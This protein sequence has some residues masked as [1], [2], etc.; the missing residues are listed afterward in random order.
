[1]TPLLELLTPVIRISPL[2]K[3]RAGRHITGVLGLYPDRM[4]M[5]RVVQNETLPLAVYQPDG[6]VALVSFDRIKDA[7]AIPFTDIVSVHITAESR[8]LARPPGFRVEIVPL[9]GDPVVHFLSYDGARWVFVVLRLRLGPRVVDDSTS[10]ALTETR[11]PPAPASLKPLSQKPSQ[12]SPSSRT[13]PMR[14]ARLGLLCKILGVVA[15]V[16]GYVAWLRGAGTMTWIPAQIRVQIAAFALLLYCMTGTVLIYLGYRL[17][18]RPA[19]VVIAGDARPPIVYLRSFTD[20]GRNTFNPTGFF[21]QA[22]GLEPSALLKVLGPLSNINPLRIYRLVRSRNVDSAEEQLGAELAKRGPLVAIGKP[23]ETLSHGGAAR[24]YVTN[25]SWQATVQ[26]MV[27]QAQIVVL[28]PADTAGV[29][30]EVDYVMR[31][32]PPERLLISLVNYRGKQGAYDNLRVRMDREFGVRLPPSAGHAIFLWFG[33]DW[34]VHP[35]AAWYRPP[36]QWPIAQTAI[37]MDRTLAPFLASLDGAPPRDAGTPPVYSHTR[38]FAAV[39][40]WIIIGFVVNAALRTA[41]LSSDGFTSA[42]RRTAKTV[43]GAMHQYPATRAYYGVAAPYR[44]TLDTAWHETNSGGTSDSVDA[45]IFAL[46]RVR[47]VLIAQ[48]ARQTRSGQWSG[49]DAAMNDA[50]T[51]IRNTNDSVEIAATHDTTIDGQFW[52]EA[53]VHVVSRDSTRT[54]E[55]IAVRAAGGSRGSIEIMSVAARSVAD[56]YEPVL[57]EARNAFH[58]MTFEELVQLLHERSENAETETHR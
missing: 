10:A 11:E 58:W 27:A 48:E 38:Q 22:L 23:G 53:L 57:G 40:A 24:L 47:L 18:L 12:G 26:Q 31:T 13:L 52:H 29:W 42:D 51:R 6:A 46:S 15:F 43:V 2:W 32:V 3:K 49:S 33:R 28:Q 25:D 56:I 4:V 34:T 41:V 44:L 8:T 1:V 54:P 36:L 20:D 5:G 7:V 19:D 30:W 55:D 21:A 16:I 35:L 50:L 9:E 39:F 37:Q 45:R 17:S 14:N